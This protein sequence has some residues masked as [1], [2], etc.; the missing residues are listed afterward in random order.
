MWHEV[1]LKQIKAGLKLEFSFS[2]TG[3]L[4]KAKEPS[5][6]NDLPKA[7]MKRCINAF[8]KAFAWSETASARF[9]L[10]PPVHFLAQ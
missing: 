2:L 1:N 3:F 7:G 5:L 10:G 9:E 4:I 8:E 6:S